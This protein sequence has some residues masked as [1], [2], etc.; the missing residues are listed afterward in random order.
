MELRTP[1]VDSALG[2]S[3]WLLLALLTACASVPATESDASQ[4]LDGG[5]LD[6]SVVDTIERLRVSRGR[7]PIHFD[8]G[9]LG[10]AAGP[11]LTIGVP[12]D[13]ETDPVFIPLAAGGDIPL[14]TFGQGATHAVF[15]VEVRGL[16]ARTW[17]DLTMHSLAE[18]ALDAGFRDVSSI[19]RGEPEPIVCT[20][21]GG[22][23]VCV[24]GPFIVITSGLA[25]PRDMDGLH[26][27]V[28]AS[29]T[30]ADGEFVE[31]ATDGYFRA[32]AAP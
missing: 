24:R 31:A 12:S 25:E 29:A 28:T 11:S 3:G 6:S 1:R 2:R 20:G 4:A 8:G 32:V 26:I 7:P 13:A 22:E 10:G 9:L 21:E 27:S 17:I 5:G 14:D 18:G 23:S 15:M 16:G 30:N 19:D